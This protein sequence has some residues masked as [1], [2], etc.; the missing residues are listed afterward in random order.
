[1]QEGEKEYRMRVSISIFAKKSKILE[2]SEQRKYF[3]NREDRGWKIERMED[4]DGSIMPEKER[5]QVLP[6]ERNAYTE[7]LARVSALPSF[8][9]KV[10][11]PPQRL[12]HSEESLS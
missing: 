11:Q 4:R 6:F 3:V 2:N 9:C 5:K 12:K 1:M 7:R 10:T 8:P